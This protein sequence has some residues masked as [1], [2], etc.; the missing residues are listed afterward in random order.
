MQIAV[1]L[2]KTH[3]VTLSINHPLTYLP[4]HLFRKSIFNWLEKLCFIVRRSKYK[5]GKWFQRERIPF[6]D[7][8]VRTH[9]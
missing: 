9:S 8:K 4:L 5:E 1:E 7:L 2:A 6:L 3:E